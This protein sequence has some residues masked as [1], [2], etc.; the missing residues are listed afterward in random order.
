MHRIISFSMLIPPLFVSFDH[1]DE[2]P[3]VLALVADLCRSRK[4]VMHQEKAPLRQEIDN[5]KW[6]LLQFPLTTMMFCHIH[7]SQGHLLRGRERYAGH[8][9]TL[10]AEGV[11]NF[12]PK[13]VGDR[14]H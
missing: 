1:V 5:L 3:L 8:L 7:V 12:P 11:A 2:N 6:N 10:V 14:G 4:P 9:A 13:P